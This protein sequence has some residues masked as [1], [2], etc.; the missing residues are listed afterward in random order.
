MIK[1]ILV[2]SEVWTPQLINTEVLELFKVIYD[3][4]CHDIPSL[5]CFMLFFISPLYFP[6]DVPC[7]ALLLRVWWD[8]LFY[9]H[10]LPTKP[11]MSIACDKT[12]RFFIEILTLMGSH[13]IFHKEMQCKT[14]VLCV[15]SYLR[16]KFLI[17]L[18]DPVLWSKL[19]YVCGTGG[20]AEHQL[21]T[22][23]VWT[24]W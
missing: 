11:N 22:E 8:I 7:H 21:W 17:H 16:L 10:S 19:L 2:L 18:R 24:S 14:E 5:L 12:V 1:I 6:Q 15:T 4:T 3:M 9:W 13:D 23:A 20:M